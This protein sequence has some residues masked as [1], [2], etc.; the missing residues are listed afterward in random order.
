M[1]CSNFALSKIKYEE[2][3]Y[4]TVEHAFQ[5]I[6][7][8]EAGYTEL[9]ED[10]R[11]MRSPYKVKSLG[12]NITIGKAWKK[13][14]ENVMGELIQAKFDQNSHDKGTTNEHPALEILWNDQR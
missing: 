4:P 7:A 11:A 12:G 1:F 10:M 3:V 14:A 8:R 6:R 13:Q 9:A 5:C 2:V